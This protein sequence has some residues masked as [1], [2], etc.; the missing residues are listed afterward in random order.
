MQ[1]PE[2]KETLHK[3]QD[4]RQEQDIKNNDL[5][6]LIYVF[7]LWFYYHLSLHVMRHNFINLIFLLLRFSERGRFL[8]K[9][10]PQFSHYF[11]HSSRGAVQK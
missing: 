4:T 7:Y 10:L 1:Y 9:Q 11:K 8:L 3:E 6:P 2:S 5:V